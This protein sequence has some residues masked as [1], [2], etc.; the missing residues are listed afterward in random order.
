LSEEHRFVLLPLSVPWYVWSRMFFEQS[1]SVCSKTYFRFSHQKCNAKL[2]ALA[3]AFCNVQMP[4]YCCVTW[5]ETRNSF[6]SL[7][8]LVAKFWWHIPFVFLLKKI[9]SFQI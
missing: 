4:C 8:S 5:Y 3:R 1:A 2:C 6:F 9:T 7:L